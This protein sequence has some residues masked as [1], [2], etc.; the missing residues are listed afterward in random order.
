MAATFSPTPMNSA[1]RSRASFTVSVP[2]GGMEGRAERARSTA[3]DSSSHARSDGPTQLPPASPASR[4]GAQSMSKH[5]ACALFHSCI[6]RSDGWLLSAPSPSGCRGAAATAC[7]RT[8][9]DGAR[10]AAIS[11]ASCPNDAQHHPN[12]THC[13]CQSL[14]KLAAVVL[15]MQHQGRASPAEPWRRQ[16][17]QAAAMQC[18][19]RGWSRPA[20]GGSGC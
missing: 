9:E 7:C 8:R 2:A 13:C 11:P 5:T 20:I 10:Q 4:L 15:Y 3:R 16:S 18:A 6:T 19:P 17:A 1:S 14:R 12:N